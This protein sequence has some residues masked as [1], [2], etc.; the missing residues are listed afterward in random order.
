MPRNP[1]TGDGII[2]T[3]IKRNLRKCRGNVLLTQL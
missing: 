2:I 3:P 1:V